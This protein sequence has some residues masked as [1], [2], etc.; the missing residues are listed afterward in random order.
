M[1]CVLL[2]LLARIIGTSADGIKDQH[3]QL[4]NT[5]VLTKRQDLEN[6]FSTFAMLESPKK[7]A[8]S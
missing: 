4:E 2:Q 3:R 6:V 7:L 1:G 8:T 5:A